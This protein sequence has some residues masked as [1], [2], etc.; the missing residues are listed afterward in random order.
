MSSDRTPTNTVAH[1]VAIVAARAADA[2]QADS[3]MVLDVGPII[4]ICD[5]FVICSA[6]NSRLVAAVAQGIFGVP[7]LVCRGRQFFGLD[8]LPML[9]AALDGDAWFDGPAWDDA[10]S[11]PPGLQ[12]R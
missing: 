4:G 5:Y 8:A 2:K 6:R 7:T 3:V 12:R 11:Q 9:R 1:D 10:G